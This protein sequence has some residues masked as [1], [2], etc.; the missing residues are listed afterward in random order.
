MFSLS[1][2]LVWLFWVWLVSLLVVCLIFS[3]SAW[4]QCWSAV[5]AHFPILSVVACDASL[6]TCTFKVK[7]R[8]PSFEFCLLL[9]VHSS[10]FRLWP[11]LHDQPRSWISQTGRNPNKRTC[12]QIL[13]L[14]GAF[15]DVRARARWKPSSGAVPM[16]YLS[17]SGTTWCHREQRPPGAHGTNSCMM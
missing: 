3:F 1:C 10:L 12:R 11:N 4:F 15:G 9:G 13:M 14:L 6:A 8:K 7:A 17:K 5:C 2:L 16:S